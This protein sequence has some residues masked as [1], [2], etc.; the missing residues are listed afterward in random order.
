MKKISSFKKQAFLFVFWL[1]LIVSFVFSAF[2]IVLRANGYQLNSKTWKVTKTGMII[3]DGTPRGAD[4]KVNNK[5][6]DYQLPLRLSNLASGNYDVEITSASYQKWQ[7]TI[8]VDEGMATSYQKIVLF[9]AKP[10]EISVSDPNLTVEELKQQANQNNQDLVI[11]G[12]EIF[13]QDRLIT[14][15]SSNVL[16][17]SIYPDSNHVIFQINNEIRAVELDGSNNTLL[18]TL[19]S[20]DPSAFIFQNSAKTII[21]IDQNQIFA[22]NIR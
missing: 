4:V 1:A 18:F 5:L 14:R 16:A 10:T 19:K 11:S 21:Y 3:L 13:W 17:A 15:F 7:R 8:R 2:L 12:N 9:L 22:K 20:N 6:N